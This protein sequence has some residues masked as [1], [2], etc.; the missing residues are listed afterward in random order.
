[1][2]TIYI[3]FSK[4]QEFSLEIFRLYIL[5][6]LTSMGYQCTKSGDLLKPV[7][8]KEKIKVVL[9]VAVACI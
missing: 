6:R 4:I 3:H 5:I 9:N 2:I 7:R 8:N 1:M